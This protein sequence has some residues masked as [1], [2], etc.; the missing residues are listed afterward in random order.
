MLHFR[1]LEVLDEIIVHDPRKSL[2]RDKGFF[3][4]LDDLFRD[5]VQLELAHARNLRP[6]ARRVICGRCFSNQ[7]KGTNE[8]TVWN[9]AGADISS[10]AL[11]QYHF[12]ASD[13][14]GSS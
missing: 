10:I 6:D 9:W 5:P 3:G 2:L 4:V 13:I 1:L 12:T 11:R 8:R 7:P 14:F